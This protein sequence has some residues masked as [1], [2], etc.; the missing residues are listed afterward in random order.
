MESLGNLIASSPPGY[1]TLILLCV[2]M[3]GLAWF[4][5]IPMFQENKELKE[6]NASLQSEVEKRLAE[7]ANVTDKIDRILKSSD[8]K[9]DTDAMQAIAS[10][11][12][13]MEHNLTTSTISME[14]ISR[15]IEELISTQESLM[16]I[17]RRRD[18][19]YGLSFQRYDHDLRAINDKLSQLV[20][21]LY[22]SPGG[23]GPKRGLQ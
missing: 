7:W 22:A 23:R 19:E 11:R 13:Y 6:K 3:L 1:M 15:A 16:E 8:A 14:S 9:T 21:A 18:T 10:L 2:F 20:G 5:G 12:L 17:Q 4:F